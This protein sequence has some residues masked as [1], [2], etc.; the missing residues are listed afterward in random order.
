M[1]SAEE[2]ARDWIWDW[3]WDWDW[4]MVWGPTI[5]SIG[6]SLIRERIV[7]LYLSFNDKQPAR[8]RQIS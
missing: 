5:T 8:K 4:G 3:D 6:F 7:G 2:A 1:L